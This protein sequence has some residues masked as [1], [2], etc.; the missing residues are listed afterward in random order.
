[1]KHLDRIQKYLDGKMNESELKK[2]RS[3]LQK[4][5]E[6]VE[7]L[8]L[9]RSVNETVL[10]TDEIRF[11]KKLEEAY[12]TYKIDGHKEN[13]SVSGNRTKLKRTIVFSSA[14]MITLLFLFI[15]SEFRKQSNDEIFEANLIS[16]SQDF[17]SRFQPE[18]ANQDQDLQE[19]IKL[20]VDGKYSDASRVF[21]QFLGQNPDNTEASFYNGLCMVFLNEFGNAISAFE[22]VLAA[23]YSYYQEYASWYLALCYIKTNNT[24]VAKSLLKE[25][26]GNDSSFSDKARRILRKLR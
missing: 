13:T 8:D 7:E 18:F 4:D 10:S 19:G 3:D 17:T 16:F 21:H 25:I 11:R 24:E 5:P 12:K 9:H 22:F 6:L 2:F 15:L 20:F 23:P 26:S 1:M 14:L